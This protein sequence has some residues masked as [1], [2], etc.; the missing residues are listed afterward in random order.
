MSH[1]ILAVCDVVEEEIH[2]CACVL[3]STLENGCVLPGEGSAEEMCSQRLMEEA[4]QFDSEMI[5]I[6]FVRFFYLN[7]VGFLVV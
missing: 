5:Y 2:R 6:Y 7:A 3:S 4:G 1:P